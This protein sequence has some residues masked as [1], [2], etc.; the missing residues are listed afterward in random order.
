RLALTLLVT[1]SLALGA[2]AALQWQASPYGQSPLIDEEGYVRWAGRIAAGDWLGQGVFYQD[3]L[4]PYLLALLFRISGSSLL[5]ARFAQV[6]AGAGTV[7]L[8]YFA[9]RR[10]FGPREALV[11]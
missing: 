6:L 3:P 10:L 11:A 4:Y 1:L 5:F 9:A 2:Q 8:L 7:A